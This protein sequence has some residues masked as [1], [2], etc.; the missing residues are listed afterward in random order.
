[1]RNEE[2]IAKNVGGTCISGQGVEWMTIQ[3][4]GGLL[5]MVFVNWCSHNHEDWLC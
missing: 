2:V 5:I 4:G 1:M 3:V